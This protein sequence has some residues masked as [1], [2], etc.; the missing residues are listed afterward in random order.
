MTNCKAHPYIGFRKHKQKNC[1]HCGKKFNPGG[2]TTYCSQE[3]YLAD[4]ALNHSVVNNCQFCGVKFRIGK[5]AM[6]N[7]N[8]RGKYCSMDCKEFAYALFVKWPKGRAVREISKVCPGCGV[9]FKQLETD[10]QRRHCTQS[11]ANK[12][13][14][15]HF[16]RSGENHWNWQGGIDEKARG[17]RHSYR[18]EKWRQSVFERDDHICQECGESDCELHAHHVFEFVN[19][20]EHRLEVWNGLTLCRDCHEKIHGTQAA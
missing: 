8:G 19:Y 14:S 13:N 6:A 18:Y 10:S 2:R 4:M 3:C 11:C 17:V 5:S 20:P 9:V 15:A 7:V 1:K 12:A 16:H